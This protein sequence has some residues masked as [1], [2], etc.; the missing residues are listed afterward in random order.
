LRFEFCAKNRLLSYLAGMATGST[1]VTRSAGSKECARLG[2]VAESCAVSGGLLFR[3][4]TRLS[5]SGGRPTGLLAKSNLVSGDASSGCLCFLVTCHRSG[6]STSVRGLVQTQS[7]LTLSAVC[8]CWRLGHLYGTYHRSSPPS[9]ATASARPAK[10]RKAA[11]ILS[12]SFCSLSASQPSATSVAIV[13][14]PDR[15][16]GLRP[17]RLASVIAL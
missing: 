17:R 6:S 8:P 11:T 9:R 3:T 1:G 10:R 13:L 12:T 2:C 7:H 16:M 15:R 5:R 4:Y 14:L